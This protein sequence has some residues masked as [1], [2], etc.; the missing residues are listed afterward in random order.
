[1][2]DRVYGTVTGMRWLEERGAYYAFRL[3]AKA[4]NLYQLNEKGRHVRFDLT[5]ELKDWAEGKTLCFS[6]FYRH[7]RVKSSLVAKYS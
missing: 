1:M 2:A 7:W 6:V 4:F 3:K 5:E